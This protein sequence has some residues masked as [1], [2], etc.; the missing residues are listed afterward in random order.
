MLDMAR[1]RIRSHRPDLVLFV[2]N[3]SDI[4]RPRNW[5]IFEDVGGGYFRFYMS[6]SAD[7]R[8]LGVNTARVNP[9]V[10]S[11]RFTP[12]WC[13][14]MLAAKTAN[15][16]TRILGDSAVKE[17]VE[18]FRTI[19]HFRNA[20]YQH[21]V[22]LTTLTTSYVWTR[23]RHGNPYHDLEVFAAD[24]NPVAAI[25][26]EDFRHDHGFVAGLDFLRESGVPFA[27]AHL[28]SYT[29]MNSGQE[30]KFGIH[31]VP[32]DREE[33]L[34]KSLREATGAPIGSLLS[35]MS[36]PVA[37]AAGL[38]SGAFPPNMDWHPNA[39]GTKRFGSALADFIA[40][41]LQA[42]R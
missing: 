1:A 24:K 20:P 12:D 16:E 15:D 38:V 40:D 35:Y 17:A 13:R 10:V 37:N 31:G 33:K 25:S 22:D 8:A 39:A 23:L 36:P 42:S 14:A 32:G 7:S 3:T 21:N 27:F 9:Q 6:R 19:R 30:F 2:F 28:P 34:V 29:E 5:P 26:I 18:Q 4:S 41:R 11:A